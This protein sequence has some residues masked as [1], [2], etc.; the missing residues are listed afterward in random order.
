MLNRE[1]S[2]SAFAVDVLPRSGK[3]STAALAA[4]ET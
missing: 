1:L 2:V 3:L 4:T